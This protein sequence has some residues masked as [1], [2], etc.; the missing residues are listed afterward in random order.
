MTGSNTSAELAAIRAQL[1]ARQAAL[2][3]ERRAK[4]EKRAERRAHSGRLSLTVRRD[5]LALLTAEG[6]LTDDDLIAR[7]AMLV[8]AGLARPASDHLIRQE[9]DGLVKRG[10]ITA[11][12]DT[13]TT[14]SGRTASTWAAVDLPAGEVQSRLIR[15]NLDDLGQP[16]RDAWVK[17]IGWRG[18]TVGDGDPVLT[19][20]CGW[21]G[22]RHH[23]LYDPDAPEITDAPCGQGPIRVRLGKT[24]RAT[25]E[26]AR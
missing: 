21:C 2:D 6:P 18:T 1:K 15:R 24:Q 9:R 25:I 17:R 11:T 26:G 22:A 7:Y 8:T 14:R 20:Q 19:I 10:L 4:R 13:T 3:E 12:G 16:F 5:V 23:L